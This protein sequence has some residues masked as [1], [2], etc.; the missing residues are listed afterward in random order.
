MKFQEWK[1]PN[2]QNMQ[3]PV[4]QYDLPFGYP[5]R[6]QSMIMVN[7]QKPAIN[8]WT[9]ELAFTT[10]AVLPSSITV[11]FNNVITGFLLNAFIMS[12]EAYSA[13]TIG[14]TPTGATPIPQLNFTSSYI[15][16]QNNRGYNFWTNKPFR[17]LQ[18]IN[19]TASKGGKVY[20]DGLQGTVV[21]W[22]NS[23][24]LIADTSSLSTSTTYSILFGISFSLFGNWMVDGQGTA[25]PNQAAINT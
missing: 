5:Y 14:K 20:V 7:G 4:D 13:A 22:Q 17:D 3:M 6:Q 1:G 15:N 2:G 9:V 23:S 24:V 19:D 21:N 11:S 25:N 12:I 10:A 18:T 16:L 8:Y